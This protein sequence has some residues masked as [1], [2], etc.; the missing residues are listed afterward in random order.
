MARAIWRRHF[1]WLLSF[2][3]LGSALSRIRLAAG[4]VRLER[5]ERHEALGDVPLAFVT[6]VVAVVGIQLL[7]IGS[8]Y[9][10]LLVRSTKASQARF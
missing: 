2:I 5:K 7:A 9:P 3:Y 8:L 4:L 1:P 10:L 6:G